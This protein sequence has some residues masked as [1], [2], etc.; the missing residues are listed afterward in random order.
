MIKVVSTKEFARCLRELAKKGKRGKDAIMKARAAQSE[1]AHEGRISSLP[2]TNNG[3]TRVPN[4]EK[5]NLGD[6]YRLVVQKIDSETRAFLYVGDHDDTDQWLENHKHY[7]WVKGEK[8]SILDF[9]QVS[10][11]PSTGSN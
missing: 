10:D 2:G 4:V 7:K 5:F 9:V 1:Y 8:D 11:P 6:G 3:E